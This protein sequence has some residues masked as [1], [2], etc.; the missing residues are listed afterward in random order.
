MNPG[1]GPSFAPRPDFGH[2]PRGPMGSGPPGPNVLMA[3]GFNPDTLSCESIFNLL[4]PFG[5][6]MKVRPIYINSFPVFQQL[7]F[8][9]RSKISN[10]AMYW[11]GIVRSFC[12]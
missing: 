7:N 11:L 6:V 2:G 4:C 5:N 3:Y 1:P 9:A 10:S 12:G 8:F